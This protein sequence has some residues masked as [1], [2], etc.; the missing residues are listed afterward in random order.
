MIQLKFV[1]RCGKNHSGLFVLLVASTVFCLRVTASDS[2]DNS[3]AK[4]KVIV[5]AKEAPEAGVWQSK[6]KELMEKWHP[7]IADML[8]TDG[9]VP[10]SE[11]KLVFKKDM[12]GPASTSGST[13]SISADHIRR[14]PNDYGMV[15]HELVHVLQ[16]YPKFNKENW[17]LVEGLADYIRFY[18]YEPKTK[19][20]RINPAKASYRDGYKTSARF[21]AWIERR[22]DKA[23][24]TKLNAALRKGEYKPELFETWTGRS[25]DQLWTEFVRAMPAR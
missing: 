1:P 20:P 8:K 9:F 24:I 11:V 18:L 16:R 7:I 3:A 22:H 25:L 23:I 13:I 2:A 10:A 4:V 5:D 14:N 19:L 12:R 15:V 17:W 21:L 6:A